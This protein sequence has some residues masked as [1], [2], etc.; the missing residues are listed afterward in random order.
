MTS[1]GTTAF[2]SLLRA[3]RVRSLFC[4]LWMGAALSLAG[5][6]ASA[7]A[8]DAD[9]RPAALDVFVRQ[10]NAR[11]FAFGCVPMHWRLFNAQADAWMQDDDLTFEQRMQQSVFVL[12]LK[13]GQFD[14]YVI[15]GQPAWQSGT[16]LEW[17][18]DFAAIGY[19]VRTEERGAQ[20]AGPLYLISMWLGPSV[21]L[22]GFAAALAER[23]SAYETIQLPSLHYRYLDGE[24]APPAQTAYILDGGQMQELFRLE[25]HFANN[26]Y[27]VIEPTDAS[28]A[29][30]GLPVFS[31]F[32][33]TPIMAADMEPLLDSLLFRHR[34][35]PVPP[36]PTAVTELRTPLGLLELV[37]AIREAAQALI[38]AKTAEIQDDALR[39]AREMPYTHLLPYQLRTSDTHLYWAPF[40]LQ[41]GRLILWEYTGGAHGNSSVATWTFT[42]DGAPVALSDILD[43]PET[44]ALAAIRTAAAEHLAR[45]PAYD[46]APPESAAQVAQDLPHL[47]AVTAWNPMIRNG[48]PGLWVTFEPYVIAAYAFGVQEFFVPLPLKAPE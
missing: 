37:P 6:A 7:W 2:L 43:V 20:A 27:V 15:G 18:R 33:S 14:E 19:P 38:D 10:L 36:S 22:D 32:S 30:P 21:D 24:A 5:P 42:G 48:Q 26:K 23:A 9:C 35:P 12:Q 4:A 8:Q 40:R 45:I 3:K 17:Q 34:L 41:T 13:G 44:E 28:R 25:S 16:P 31:F 47:E 29:L 1:I 11:G 39:M 46:L